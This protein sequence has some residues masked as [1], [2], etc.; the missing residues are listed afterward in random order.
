MQPKWDRIA[1]N[2]LVSGVDND[3]LIFKHR[4]PI[5]LAKRKQTNSCTIYVQYISVG[6]RR[7]CSYLDSWSCVVVAFVRRRR[8]QHEHSRVLVSMHRVLFFVYT[9][10][11]SERTHAATT[12]SIFTSICFNLYIYIWLCASWGGMHARLH[13][14]H[15]HTRT[16]LKNTK[17]VCT[18]SEDE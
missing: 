16:R 7:S 11:G 9:A 3:I 5:R 8:G 2:V 18:V 12:I 1:D 6:C 4:F 10:T 14:I 13:D 17:H 15:T